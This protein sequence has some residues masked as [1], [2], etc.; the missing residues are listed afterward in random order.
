MPAGGAQAD[1]AFEA[2]P[3][4]A[5]NCATGGGRIG[6]TVDAVREHLQDVGEL[7]ADDGGDAAQRLDV[8]H[9]VE[10]FGAD[11][12]NRRHQPIGERGEPVGLG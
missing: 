3:G 8:P 12:R 9:P 4:H 2:G 11:V 1:T 10:P 6:E 5:D 7:V